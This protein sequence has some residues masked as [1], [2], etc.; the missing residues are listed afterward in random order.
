[1]AAAI[2][3]I[4]DPYGAA[5]ASAAALAQATGVDR[6]DVAVVLGSGWRPA[7]DRLGDLVAEVPVEQLGGFPDAA[8]EGHGST[9]RSLAGPGGRVLA[10]M[11]RVHLYE[12]HHPAVVA[13]AVRTAVRAGCRT[14][15]LTNAAGGIRAGMEVG[16]PV[17][18]ADHVNLTG[19]TPLLG[20]N[21][22][23]LGPRF[24]DMTDAYSRRLR[25]LAREVEPSL[26][27]GVY[28]GFLGPTYETPAEV[29]AARALGADLVGM[30]TV[31]ETIAAV[32]AGA[33]VLAV[34]LVT[35]LA[36]GLGHELLDHADVL[37]A[38]A[39]AADRMGA[40]IAAVVGRI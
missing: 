21:D 17:L 39:A 18:V 3:P 26:A 9:V 14:V 36:A 10:F 35:N 23:R 30:S 8:V 31:L 25:A 38:A 37:A 32:H 40:L 34:S 20:P 19:H 13:H 5:D 16:Q 12:G 1:M 6:H 15:V 11:G 27:E 22:A 28:C 24:P 33:E 2:D 4:A 29:T 7:A